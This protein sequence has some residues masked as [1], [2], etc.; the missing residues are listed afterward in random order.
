MYFN[1]LSFIFFF[2]AAFSLYY[3]LPSR[4]RA[5]ILLVFSL[6]FFLSNSL[7]FIFVISFLVLLDY[8]TVIF[9][10]KKKACRKTILVF[11]ISVNL[12]LLILFKYLNFLFTSLNSAGINVFINIPQTFYE[13]FIPLGFSFFVFKSISFLVESF[14]GTLKE[15]LSLRDLFLYFLFFPSVL[16]GPIDR[17]GALLNQFGNISDDF[18]NNIKTGLSFIILGYIKKSVIAD[19]LSYF[20]DITYGNIDNSSWFQILIAVVF[21]SFQIYLDFSGYSDMALGFARMF[22]ISIM[23]NFEKPYFAKSIQDFW[24]RWH[25]SLSTWLRDYLFLP[26]AYSS[27]RLMYRFRLTPKTIEKFSY[28]YSI[29]ITMF[30]AGL[31]H[32]ANITFI[33]WGLIMGVYIV[34]SFL[35]KKHRSRFKKVTGLNRYKSFVSVYQSAFLFVIVTFAWIFFRAESAG[36]AFKIAGRLFFPDF[37]GN[38][39]FSLNTGKVSMV[40]SVYY[41]LVLIIFIVFAEYFN[42]RERILSVIG[43]HGIFYRYAL[44]IILILF[45]LFAGNFSANQFI[46]FRF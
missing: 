36:E 39:L 6:I 24:R 22:G 23:Q 12:V 30:L 8:I 17:P 33:L 29:L 13:V 35:T 46:Y 3:I 5:N 42:F 15:K 1:T 4:F 10:D 20:V 32:G 41:P 43:N 18:S 45:I 34:T 25:V 11:S 37:N 19:R 31:W 2:G 44:V 28:V 38:N 14:R 21:Y 26:L 7:L 27:T 16:S 9:F 40:F